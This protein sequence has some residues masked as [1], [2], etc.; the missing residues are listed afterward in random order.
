ME[1]KRDKN[2]DLGSKRG[3][4]ILQR[5]WRSERR[6]N[7]LCAILSFILLDSGRISNSMA[8]NLQTLPEHYYLT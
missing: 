7:S 3:L 8:A 5:D 1:E 6:E 4:G 2:V